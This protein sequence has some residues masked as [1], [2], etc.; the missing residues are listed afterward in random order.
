[1]G[2]NINKSIIDQQLTGIEEQIRKQAMDEFGFS[3]DRLKSLAF[4]Y[5]CVKT[6]LDLDPEEAF[7]C[8][9]DGAGDF[10]VD[11]VHTSVPMDGDVV[12]TLFQGKYKRDLDVEAAFE[13]TSIEKLI[14]ACRYFFDPS[15][16]LQCL[17]PRLLIKVEEIRSLIREGAIPTIRVIACNNG[18]RWNKP[19]DDEIDRFGHKDRISWEH[20]NHDVLVN[21]LQRIRPVDETISLSGK[22][23]I[24]DMNFSRVCIGRVAV[25]EVA[26]LMKTHGDRL[27]ER[28][29]RSYLGL[30]GNRVNEAIRNTL[31]SKTSSDFYLFNNGLT[32]LCDD[33]IYN[34]LQKED[35]KIQLENLQIVNGGQTCM[36]IF[37]TDEELKKQGSILPEDAYVLIRIYKLHKDN[38]ETVS[39]ITQATN[40]QNPVDLKDLRA[41][42]EIQKRLE[43]SIGNLGYTYRRRRMEITPKLTEIT[44]GAAAV[45]VLSVWQRAPHQAKFY[46]REHFGKLYPDIFTEKLN[47]AQV[48]LAVLLYRFAENRRRRP[49]SGDPPFVP[50]ASCFLAML[51]GRLLLKDMKLVDHETLDHR[52]FKTAK[53]LL[54]KKDNAYFEGAIEE[55]KNAIDRLYTDGWANQSLQ[56]LS[57]TFRRGDLISVLAINE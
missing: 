18:P 12:V 41:N 1:M 43:L 29:I 8:L 16:P 40:S 5:L 4:V 38:H 36:T 56:Q 55:L 42:D 11:A 15:A 22:A 50:Y 2:I 26:R 34:S 6:M 20:V 39:L 17:N 27:L 45:A 14:N 48:I 47:G 10:G 33:F 25:S 13:G 7:D 57:A 28:N 51:M 44:T 53:D 19:A 21:I 30:H 37:K 52:N 3:G 31:T 9:T 32:V 46:S 49:Q 23:I 35:H 24:E 54:D